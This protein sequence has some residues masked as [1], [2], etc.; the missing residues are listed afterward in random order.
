MEKMREEDNKNEKFLY[1]STAYTLHPQPSSNTTKCPHIRHSC[2]TGVR[3][4]E[5][6]GGPASKE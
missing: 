6:A 4:V 1:G 2:S 5:P 3:T